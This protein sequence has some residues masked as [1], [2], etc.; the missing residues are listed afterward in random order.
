MNKRSAYLRLMRISLL[1]TAWSNVLLGYL[2]MQPELPNQSALLYVAGLLVC[3]SCFYIAGMVFN[4]VCDIELD[5]VERPERVLPSK[6]VSL[7][8]ARILGYC[9]VASGLVIAALL[10]LRMG[11]NGPM[12]GGTTLAISLVL[13]GL[14]FFYNVRAK[15]TW[16][17]PIVMGLCRSF[18]VL[19]GGSLD[20]GLHLPEAE[21][22]LWV[23]AAV[24]TYVAGITWLAKEGKPNQRSISAAGR[25]AHA[26]GGRGDSGLRVFPSVFRFLSDQLFEG[27]FSPDAHS[28]LRL[29]GDNGLSSCQESACCLGL[30]KTTRCESRC[31]YQSANDHFN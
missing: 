27:A 29:V 24:G 5:R 18:N 10:S 30:G 11:K 22:L 20:S 1:P 4:D 16:F 13:V 7:R 28:V 25:D 8:S 15:R 26:F 3:S 9:L 21:G 23:A 17:G 12:I 14:I 6:Q 19:F 2:L 31:D